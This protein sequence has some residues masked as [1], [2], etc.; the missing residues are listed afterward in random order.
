MPKLVDFYRALVDAY[1]GVQARLSGIMT[2]MF[3]IPHPTGQADGS[4]FASCWSVWVNA[5][6][7]HMHVL[8]PLLI[9]LQGPH[10]RQRRPFA[11]LAFYQ[12][13]C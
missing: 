5:S 1:P 12:T 4:E 9:G 3:R 10:H 2:C 13:R 7:C 11:G 8:C 6:K